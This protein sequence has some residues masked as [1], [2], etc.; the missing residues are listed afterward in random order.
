VSKLGLDKII[1]RRIVPDDRPMLRL[2]LRDPDVRQAIQD[3]TIDFSRMKETI[4]LFE[5]SDP[6]RD[7]GLG[8]IVEVAGRP[9]GLI[10]FVWINWV[11]RNAEVIV[12]VGPGELRRSL[13]A[14]I[15]VEKIGHTAFRV[16]NLHKIYAFVYRSN[17][18]ALSVFRKIMKEEACLRAYVKSPE[19]YS[20][21]HF[22]GLLSSEYFSTMKKIK[23]AA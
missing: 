21:F 7:G 3:E 6:F 4:E 13:A 5:S 9:I 10:Q 2:W 14:A 15:V 20:D 17:A 1:V 22:F 19:G 11:S 8:L 12:F 18:A 16:L 23:G